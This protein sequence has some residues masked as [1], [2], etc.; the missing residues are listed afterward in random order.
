MD[1]R[2]PLNSLAIA[3]SLH[4]APLKLI[5]DTDDVY[6]ISLI[7]AL[8]N[9]GLVDLI[10]IIST[11]DHPFHSCSAQ[12]TDAVNNFYGC[13]EKAIRVVHD[14]A[15]KDKRQFRCVTNRN[16]KHSN[17]IYPFISLVPSSSLAQIAATLISPAPTLYT[18]PKS[19]KDHSALATKNYETP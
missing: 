16:D 6:V 9:T 18:Q 5:L 15:T 2:D 12:F 4:A 17:F 10:A 3:A 7:H 14:G 13:P 19:S 1:L 8:Q 11:K